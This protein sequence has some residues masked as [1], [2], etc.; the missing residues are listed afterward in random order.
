MHEKPKQIRKFHWVCMSFWVTCTILARDYTT[1]C[2]HHSINMDDSH[3]FTYISLFPF[4]YRHTN[5]T[6][7]I[8]NLFLTY[9]LWNKIELNKLLA[10]SKKKKKNTR[11]L[12]WFIL[13]R[14]TCDSGNVS[15]VYWISLCYAVACEWDEMKIKTTTY[16]RM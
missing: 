12:F 15:N 11:F 1:S 4:I 3:L 14:R 2:H 10:S 8:G 5:I 6:I 13:R 16:R 7:F 9:N